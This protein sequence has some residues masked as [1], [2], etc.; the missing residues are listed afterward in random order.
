VSRKRL[1]EEGNEEELAKL[2]GTST[3]P[4]ASP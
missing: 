3:E 1:V 2:F 4:S